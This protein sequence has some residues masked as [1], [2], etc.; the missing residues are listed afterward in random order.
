M[1]NLEELKKR[2]YKEKETF[3]ERMISPELA[4]P[5][6]ARTFFWS[7]TAR[8]VSKSRWFLWAL[9]LVFIL[10]ILGFLFF[11]F[12]SPTI[13]KS[14]KVEL[15]IEGAKE[16]KSGDRI[17][18]QVKIT[19]NNSNA[20]EGAALVFNFPDGAM[21]VS[22][23]KPVGVFRERRSLGAVRPGESASE[24]FD[25]FVFGG[26]GA[27]KEVSAVLEYR[28]SGGNAVFA[29]DA[30]FQF[31]VASAPVTVSFK[32][33][34]DLRIG[35]QL[36]IE[37]D[38][39]SQ[40][41][42]VV[43]GLSLMLTFPEG[44]EFVSAS[45]AASSQNKNIWQ[46]GDLKPSETGSIKIKGII[47]GAN[48]ESKVFKAALGILNEADNS[49]LA[50]DEIMEPAILHAPFLEAD[51]LVNDQQKYI[52]FPG[53][54]LSFE[55]RLKN[56]LP[57]E[58]KNASLEAKIES[59]DGAADLGSIRVEGGSYSESSKS[60]LWNASTHG[61]F[62]VLA[63]DAEDR[64][65]FSVKVK[66]NLPLSSESLRPSIKLSVTFNP[67]GEV[68]GFSGTDVSGSVALEIKVSSKLQA[69]ASALYA[70][71]IISNSGPLPPKTGQETTYTVFWSLA[72]M[73]NDVDNVV[74]KSSL[75]PYI[76]FKNVIMPADADISFDKAS[77]E[78][79]W[80]VGRIPAGIGFLR[81]AIQVAFQVG[82]TPSQNQVDTAPVILNATEV[83]GRD[84]YTDQILN[85]GDGPISTDLP[86]DPNIG[87]SQKK[88]VP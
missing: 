54:T 72:N 2:L 74:V 87:F 51:I 68:A 61:A 71:S 88:V 13:F 6:R 38:Y 82:L 27:I 7:E 67:G 66:N 12:G 36:E 15:K 24:N 5:K 25:A 77:N 43:S 79:I 28:P 73:A 20:L 35:Q 19:N 39:G 58:V 49:F 47:N 42:E 8:E 11:I 30:S 48:L 63:P 69:A 1:A 10:I 85:S 41:A 65:T 44:F 21:P 57:T 37:V 29:S 45:P 75:P 16:I 34:G 22:G 50:Y 62:K 70:N 81:P 14:Q 64:V 76:N 86:D 32:M 23:A 17:T 3:G 33:P 80:K 52:A 26:R 60:I 40:A 83:S 53:D 78:I 56:N 18:W 9:A 84:T 4:R 59:A 55:I 46:V 31:S